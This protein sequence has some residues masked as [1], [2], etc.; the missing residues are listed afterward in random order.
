MIHRDVKPANLL[1]G[2]DGV[3]KLGDFGM[4]FGA[5]GA[6]VGQARVRAGTPYYTAP[7]VWRGEPASAASDPLV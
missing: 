3:T 7:E 4:A 5:A 6:R 2:S 1:I